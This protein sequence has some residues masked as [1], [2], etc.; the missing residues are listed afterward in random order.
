MCVYWQT[1]AATS[2]ALHSKA[3]RR[4]IPFWLRADERLA[5]VSPGDKQTY[6]TY[7]LTTYAGSLF[8]LLLLRLGRVCADTHSKQTCLFFLSGR[9]EVQGALSPS[10]S[11]P[12]EITKARPMKNLCAGVCERERGVLFYYNLVRSK[13]MQPAWC[14]CAA[15]SLAHNRRFTMGIN[16]RGGRAATE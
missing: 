9:R 8:A 14:E 6:D 12:P 5:R 2:V 15:E 13:V 4:G 3:D 1:S 16:I 10:N 7:F 11:V